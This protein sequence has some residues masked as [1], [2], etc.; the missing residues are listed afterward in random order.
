MYV[1]WKCVISVKKVQRMKGFLVRKK[2]NLVD[3]IWME[4]E[5]QAGYKKWWGGKSF[6]YGQE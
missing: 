2:N 6:I 5:R 4:N 1:Y 3:F